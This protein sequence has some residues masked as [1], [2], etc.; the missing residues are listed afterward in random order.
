MSY[1]YCLW[2]IETIP[3]ESIK[4][5]MPESFVKYGNT[6]L[7]DKRKVILEKHQEDWDS[8]N[9]KAVKFKSLN[10]EFGQIVSS[11]IMVVSS[12]GEII[13]KDV[14]YDKETDIGI[15]E[16][17][18]E[19][20]KDRIIITWNGKGFDLPFLW[21]RSIINNT[22]L[23]FRFFNSMTKK[24]DFE[25]SIDLMHVWNDGGFGSQEKCCNA[26]GFSSK[27]EM[28]GS[29]V[30]PAFKEGRHEDIKKYNMNDVEAMLEIANRIGIIPKGLV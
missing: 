26:L 23:D 15:I 19:N 9:E 5:D 6:K 24:Y 27:S 8:N 21:K 1:D 17:T 30:Y 14:F 12:R 11:A 13:S 16:K 2:D 28:D 4:I 18:I 22:P 25:K 3:N 7:E 20:L 29:K 10:P